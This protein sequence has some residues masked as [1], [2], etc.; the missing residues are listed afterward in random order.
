MSCSAAK[1]AWRSGIDGSAVR[2]EFEFGNNLVFGGFGEFAGFGNHVLAGSD[3]RASGESAIF[4]LAFHHGRLEFTD[5][6]QFGMTG[7]NIVNH[8]TFRRAK[9]GIDVFVIGG[10]EGNMEHLF[11]R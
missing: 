2:N 7:R 11:L 9:V 5:L 6:D 4:M 10:G 3:D 8:E 1:S